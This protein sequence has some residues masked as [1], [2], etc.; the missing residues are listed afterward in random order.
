MA[1]SGV[2]DAALQDYLHANAW[3]IATPDDVQEAFAEL[4][5]VLTELEQVGAL[6]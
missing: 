2:F 4:P 5:E 6:P 3:S 1:G